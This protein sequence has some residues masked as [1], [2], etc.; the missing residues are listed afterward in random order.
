MSRT[1][2]IIGCVIL[3]GLLTSF[4]YVGMRSLGGKPSA[5]RNSRL[6][7]I[8]RR[9]LHPEREHFTKAI[10]VSIRRPVK[11]DDVKQI[12]YTVREPFRVYETMVDPQTGK[13]IQYTKVEH[14]E[15][16]RKR[17]FSFSKIEYETQK[18]RYTLNYSR[19]RWTWESF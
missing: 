10:E 8:D 16:T 2:K 19:P 17:S 7:Q 3:V 1:R 9:S 15:V 18:K 12:T 13:T 11:K 14:R 6:S 5:N 4:V